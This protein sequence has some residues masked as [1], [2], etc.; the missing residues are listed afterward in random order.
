MSGGD[1]ATTGTVTIQVD[2]SSL[3]EAQSTVE[4]SIGTIDV[5]AT[6]SATP[7]GGVAGSGALSRQ[8]ESLT[9][10][11]DG[12]NEILR[13]LAEG[14]E[15]LLEASGTGGSSSFFDG[16]GDDG[17]GFVSDIVKSVRAGVSGAAGGLATRLASRL[18]S[19]AGIARSVGSAVRAVAT[20]TG[21]GVLAGLGL[22]A[23]GIEL[24]KRT[25][26]LDAIEGFA[27]D[28]QDTL[29]GDFLGTFFGPAGIAGAL[30]LGLPDII[31]GALT[32]DSDQIT[33]GLQTSIDSSIAAYEGFAESANGLAERISGAGNDIASGIDDLASDISNKGDTFV[34]EVDGLASDLQNI[35]LPDLG[36]LPGVDPSS[37]GPADGGGG[38]NSGLID[39][40]TGGVGDIAPSIGGGG[41]RQFLVNQSDPA[42]RATDRGGGGSNVTVNS[43]VQVDGRGGGDVDERSI[44]RRIESA[45][46]D[47]LGGSGGGSDV[48]TKEGRNQRFRRSNF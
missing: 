45:V 13:G 33:D 5:S 15:E 48:V 12:R 23:G 39:R 16:G 14:V 2:E 34:S 40:I 30:S 1:F 36:D 31:G 25:G 38:G 42:V 11:A 43:R 10:L 8:V 35:D 41:D 22:G 28:L 32:L 27:N 21:G 46:R 24:L 47:E 6:T 7:D 9:E 3:K 37:G 29:A 26:V 17:G 18:P 19:A 4:E 20:S 44:Q